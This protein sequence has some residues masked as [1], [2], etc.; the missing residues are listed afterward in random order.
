AGGPLGALRDELQRDAV[1]A[2]ALIGRRRAV[3]ENMAVV[4]AAARAVIFQPRVDQEEVL[5]LLERARDGGEE[6]RPAGAGVEFHLR[7]EQRQPAARAGEH[8]RALLLVEGAR[9]GALGAFFAQ[10][11][12]RLGRQALAPFVLRQLERLARRRN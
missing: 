2:P 12:E 6:A 7:G 3:V 1:V 5:L 10:H 8:A 4:A 9:A 11:L